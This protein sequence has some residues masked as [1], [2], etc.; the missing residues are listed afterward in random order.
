[1]TSTL[2]PHDHDRG[3]EATG[4]LARALRPRAR[5]A[6]GGR[7][8]DRP[9]SRDPLHQRGPRALRHPAPLDRRRLLLRHRR[10]ARL[11]G[12][13]RRPH[14]PQADPAHGR[15]RVRADIGPQRLRDDP[16]DDDRGPG[17][18]RRGRRDPDAR[19]PRPDPQPLPRPARAQPRGRHLGRDR[20]R[21]YRGRPHRGRLPPRTLLVGFGLPHQP[22]RDGRPGRRRHQD[23]SGVPHPEPRPVG[24]AQRAAVPGRHDRHRLRRQG[25][26]HARLHRDLARHGSGGC[27]RAVRLRPPP[28]DPRRRPCWT[29]ACSATAASA[30]RSWPTC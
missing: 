6:A 1:M 23:A 16:G 12:Q 13:P 22:A 3:G 30:A 17:P 15:H 10:S 26:R 28:A 7:R 14:R 27:G 18:A 29:C 25:G 11:D 8:R 2:R 24:P 4:P 9:R 21:G 20:L 19:H 5:R